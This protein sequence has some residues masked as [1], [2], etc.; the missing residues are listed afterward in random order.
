MWIGSDHEF[1]VVHGISHRQARHFRCTGEH[2]IPHSEDGD[3]GSGNIVAACEFCNRRRH[4]RK[5]VPDPITYR[6][7]VQKRVSVGRW[8]RYLLASGRAVYRSGRGN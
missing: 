8:N 2:L 4:C 7:F 3:S 5:R 6:K 1:V